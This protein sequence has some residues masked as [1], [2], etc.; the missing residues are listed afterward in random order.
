[1]EESL[2]PRRA[3]KRV[4]RPDGIRPTTVRGVVR[5]EV[6]IG[7]DGLDT[8]IDLRPD[9]TSSRPSALT[10]AAIVA[11]PAC[12]LSPEPR[13]DWGYRIV[14]GCDQ[15][16][17]ANGFNIAMFSYSVDDPHAGAKL[18]Q[19]IEQ[20]GD[21]LAGVLCF[22][23]PVIQGL[24][25]QLDRRDLPWVTINRPREIAGQNF[26]THDAFNASRLVGRCLTKM[27]CQ[28]AVMLSDELR[29]GKSSGDKYFGLLEGWIET[30]SQ[31]RHIDFVK[32]E[33][34]T[35]EH[36]HDAFKAHVRQFGPPGAVFAS[37]DYLALGAIR[38]CRE[39]NLNVPGDV[40]VI[41][42]TGLQVG[43][44][45]HPS[46]TV[47]QTPMELLGREAAQMLLEMARG[48]HRRV[49]SRRLPAS[50]VVRESMPIPEDLLSQ[51]RAAMERTN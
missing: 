31:A 12:A 19:R 4:T 20:A 7:L 30:G 35:E 9:S 21:A 50:I 46:L 1:M 2:Q 38:A 14:C 34:Y 40:S 25:E 26:V 42:A 6:P 47:L 3:A 29:S 18:L 48:G 13:D 45:A 5:A 37:G 22:L 16:L 49:V 36:G 51:E 43:A 33:S 11:G 23:S 24:L 32:A 28:R 44:Y 15:E 17:A 27:G 8:V 39:L 10:V 41:G